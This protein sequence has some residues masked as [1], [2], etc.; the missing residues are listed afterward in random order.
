VS[1]RGALAAEDFVV[2]GAPVID[3]TSA[4]AASVSDPGVVLELE[5]GRRVL[6]GRAP[7]SGEP[8]ELPVERKWASLAKAARALRPTTVD[9]RDW[10]LLD[11]RWDIADVL[12]RDAAVLEPADTSTPPPAP[13]EV[14]KP[15]IAAEKPIAAD[16]VR[17]PDR[18]T[19]RPRADRATERPRDPPT[20]RPRV[21]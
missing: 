15:R 3:A 16:P 14:A 13:V 4:R 17:I 1:R 21:L 8:G 9:H 12:W 11:V 10:S 6:F 7:N 20:N 2:L 18:V 19:E 5:D